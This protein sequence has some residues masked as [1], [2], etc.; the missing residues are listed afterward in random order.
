MMQV[1]IWLLAFL[2]GAVLGT[3]FLWQSLVYGASVADDRLA[4]AVG[5]R[6]LFWP[7]GHCPA[8]LLPDH[9]GGLDPR[10]FA[11]L[12]GFIAARLILIR[13]FQPART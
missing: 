13:H 7:Y 10:G 4:R 9:A 3:F 2:A 5:S 1:M 6:Q 11:G 12:L 8:G